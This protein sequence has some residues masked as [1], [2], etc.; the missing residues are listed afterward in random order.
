[1]TL[2]SSCCHLMSKEAE[3]LSNA[4]KVH[5]LRVPF[6]RKKTDLRRDFPLE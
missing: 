2:F 6:F 5:P 3:N 1:M 4:K